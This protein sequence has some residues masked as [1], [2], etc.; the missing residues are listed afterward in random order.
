MLRALFLQELRRSWLAHAGLF[1][2][3]FGT[4]TLVERALTRENPLSP[5]DETFLAI[6]L[7]AGILLSGLISGER[8]FPATFK[9]GRY[10]FLLTLP[11]PRG[12]IWLAYLGG[13]LIG[14]LAALPVLLL[15]GPSLLLRWL[16]PWDSRFL[17][18]ALSVYLVFFLGS[19]TLALALRKE[20][21][22]YLIGPPLLTGLLAFLAYNTSYSYALSDLEDSSRY[23]RTLPWGSIPLALAWTAVSLRAFCRGEI[24]LGRRTARTLAEAGLASAALFGLVIIAF[25]SSK[26][27]AVGANWSPADPNLFWLPNQADSRPVSADGRFLFI[28]QRIRE[29]LVFTRLAVVDLESGSTTRW[30]ER[31]GIYQIS[32]SA[33]EAVLNVLAANTTPADCLGIPCQGSTSWY[34]LSP[35]LRVLSIRTFPGTG[36]LRQLGD[37]LLLVTQQWGTGQIY[38]LSDRDGSFAEILTAELE[39]YYANAWSLDQGGAVVLFTTSAS[40]RAWWL[41]S[42]GRILHEESVIRKHQEQYYFVGLR[43]LSSQEIKAEA[44][45]DAFPEP[46]K[47]PESWELLLPNDDG[48]LDFGSGQFYIQRHEGGEV[49]WRHDAQHG[50]WTRILSELKPGESRLTLSYLAEDTGPMKLDV[51]YRTWTWAAAVVSGGRVRLF[52][53]DNRLARS[54]PTTV[55]CGPG[56]EGRTRLQQVQGLEGLLVRFVCQG[57]TGLRYRLLEIVP[58]SGRVRELPWHSSVEVSRP[59]DRWIYL[60]PEGASVW[61]SKTGEVWQAGPGRKSLRLNPPAE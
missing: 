60:N 15:A 39:Y 44:I 53:Y 56:E 58:G 1:A 50:A 51:D 9:E 59:F 7:F 47:S 6:L 54:I 61:L 36:F 35:D 5:D 20:I 33:S 41:D 34:R 26:L 38:R 29:R 17:I 8:C 49:I 2:V 43:I 42:Q 25:S 31:S 10:A 45:Q 24:H 4:A 21:L 28:H 32:W 18:A 37:G 48:P 46:S 19:A 22:V 16:A 57:R 3:V 40:F 30:M 23:L 11:R 52:L 55:A 13:R 14:A 27:A 12:G